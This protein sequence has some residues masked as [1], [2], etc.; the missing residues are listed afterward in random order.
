M[1]LE[2]VGDNSILIPTTKECKIENDI[3]QYW[4]RIHTHRAD[5]TAVDTLHTD[6]AAVFHVTARRC[7][8]HCSGMDTDEGVRVKQVLHLREHWCQLFRVALRNQLSF[9]IAPTEHKVIVED[10]GLFLV[11]TGE[12]LAI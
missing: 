9:F 2:E 7:M 12:G 3:R 4:K 10:D 6:N 11:Q 1:I 8:A 5:E